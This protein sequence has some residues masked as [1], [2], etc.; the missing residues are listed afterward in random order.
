[1][2]SI[3]TAIH[4]QLNVN[5]IFWENLKKYTKNP[6]ELIIIDNASTDGSAEFFESVGAKVIRNSSNYSYPHSQ[7]QGIAVAKFDWLVFMNNDLVV[8]PNWDLHMMENMQHNGFEVAT[9]CGV[10]RVET[11]EATKKLKRRWNRIK[12]AL[13]IFGYSKIVLELMHKIMYWNWEKFSNNRYNKF[14]L[15]AMEGFVGST[16]MMQR[17]ALAKIGLWDETIQTADFDLYLRTKERQ[18]LHGDMKVIHI[19]LDVFVHH[20]IRLTTYANPPKFADADCLRSLED[21]WG[22]TQI[23]KVGGEYVFKK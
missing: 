2:L 6:F 3:I 19:C 17:S 20:Y 16:V 7:N 10:E 18:D 1:M 15:Q 12:T 21:K 14:K 4:N 22:L 13:S 9:V 5:Q 11:V 8:S 23:K